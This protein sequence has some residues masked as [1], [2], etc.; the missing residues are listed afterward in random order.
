MEWPPGSLYTDLL[1]MVLPLMGIKG[2]LIFRHKRLVN[3]SVHSVVGVMHSESQLS[4]H[5]NKEFN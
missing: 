3:I 1:S 2:V 5:L 4:F